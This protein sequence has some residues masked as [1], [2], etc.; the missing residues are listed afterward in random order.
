MLIKR[1][2]I[3]KF[4]QTALFMVIIGIFTFILSNSVLASP[5]NLD[6]ESKNNINEITSEDVIYLVNKSRKAEGLEELSMN[7]RLN[8]AA[9]WKAEDMI[10]NNYFAHT[11]P[12]GLSPWYWFGVY[13]YDYKY[14]GENLAV[15]FTS[16]E[17]QHNAW[18]KS[19]RHK[20]NILNPDYQETGIAVKEG[21][22]GGYFTT[23]TVQ[24]F[25]AKNKD[26]LHAV[27]GTDSE[28]YLMS[29]M[30][31]GRAAQDDSRVFGLAKTKLQPKSEGTFQPSPYQMRILYQDHKFWERFTWVAIVLILIIVIIINTLILSG[32]SYRNPFTAISTVILM[33]ILTTLIFWRI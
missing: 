10:A 27:A 11:S 8:Q 1:L 12:E 22:I 20:K 33:V 2:K 9:Q 19:S 15:S 18:M 26:L 3:D 29:I 23:I 31:N 32:V 5:V 17:S 28:L 4:P 13:G 30:Y 21:V 7:Y 16:S 25:G 24:M 6:T 14:A